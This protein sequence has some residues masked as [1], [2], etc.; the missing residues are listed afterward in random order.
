MLDHLNIPCLAVIFIFTNTYEVLSDT[1]TLHL[2]VVFLVN[3]TTF[4]F[5]RSCQK[6]VKVY[7]DVYLYTM[8]LP[9]KC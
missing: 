8:L 2:A 3:Q 7:P 4:V 5:S 1:N 6:L 9:T